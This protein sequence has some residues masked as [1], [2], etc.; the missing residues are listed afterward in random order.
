M[1]MVVS[2]KKFKRI[3]PKKFALWTAMISMIM[4]FSALTSAY[5]VQ[6]AS[7]DWLSFPIVKE[8]FLSTGVILSCSVILHV[9]YKAF[10]DKNYQLYQ[11]LL[12][13]G[14]GLGC[15][16]VALQYSG[17]LALNEMGVFVHT[18][19]SSSFFVLLVGIHALHVL[20]GIAALLI[21]WIFAMRKNTL[22]WSEKGQLR[23]ELT[24][25]YWHFVDFL[26]LYLLAF[27]WI[28]Q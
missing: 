3:H 11:I 18:N 10:V 15:L 16:F 6:K 21:S 27:L 14:F 20:G 12:T 9:A 13:I 17:W 24:F 26:W 28:Q 8:F 22:E 7:G 1:E 25:T 19:Q 5:I 4:L 2:P 23:L